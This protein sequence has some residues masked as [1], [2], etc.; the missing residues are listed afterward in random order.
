M[1]PLDEEVWKEEAAPRDRRHRF[2]RQT[3]LGSKKEGAD[4]TY[5]RGFGYHPLVF[6]FAGTDEVLRVIN[7]PGNETSAQDA[8][9]HLLDI[10]DLM[11][12]RFKRMIFRGDSAFSKQAIFDAC[13]EHDF[14]FA[15]VSPEQSNFHEI[16]EGLEER[17]WKPFRHDSERL[18]LPRKNGHPN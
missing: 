6:S 12:E 4:F 15:M 7:R 17:K 14:H 16:A 9:K 1:R 3:R 13:H 8:E 2:T 5:K 10:A 18:T 11:K